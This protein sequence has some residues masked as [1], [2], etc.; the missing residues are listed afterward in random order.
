MHG[1]RVWMLVFVACFA[2][3]MRPQSAVAQSAP[4]AQAAQPAGP[5]TSAQ[6]PAATPPTDGP[7]TQQ[8]LPPVV[9]AEPGA[10]PAPKKI[11]KAASA[12]SKS[13]PTASNP[14]P[15]AEAQAASVQ[16]G[17]NSPLAIQNDAFNEARKDIFTQVGTNAVF[18]WRRGDPSVAAGDGDAARSRFFAGAG[19]QPG[20]G[21]KRS[22]SR[23]QRPR[24]P[25][26]SHQRHSAS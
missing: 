13:V 19:R 5:N 25:A 17:P 12:K 1:L 11:K 9:V 4:G 14:P 26:I 8:Q 15:A 21:S 7:S 16:E 23:A 3:W 2:A 24:Q 6:P 22:A 18:T 20:F 10:K